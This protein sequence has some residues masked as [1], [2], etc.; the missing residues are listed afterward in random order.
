MADAVVPKTLGR[1][2]TE[3]LARVP[4]DDVQITTLGNTFGLRS[5]KISLTVL[6]SYVLYLETTAF[7]GRGAGLSKLLADFTADAGTEP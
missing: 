4:V 5:A 3:G 2:T 6:V 1:F 7:E